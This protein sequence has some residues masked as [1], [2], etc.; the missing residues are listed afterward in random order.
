MSK[1]TGDYQEMLLKRLKDEELASMY[2]TEALGDFFENDYTSQQ[3][4]LL[5]IRN[6]IE[7]HSSYQEIAKKAGMSTRNLKHTLSPDCRPRMS[8][9]F[10]VL[11]ALNYC[12]HCVKATNQPTELVI[13]E[14]KFEETED[15][16][17]YD[18]PM[19][20]CPA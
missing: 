12:I 7:S 13:E 16:E 6:V 17:A 15:I 3:V 5:S 9:I 4:L 18:A 14:I 10:N 11:L 2:I 8:T 1:V 20:Y 19:V